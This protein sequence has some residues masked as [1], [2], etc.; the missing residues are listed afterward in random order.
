V[1]YPNHI[2]NLC[3]RKRAE[4]DEDPTHECEEQG[5]L[6]KKMKIDS[7]LPEIQRNLA[8]LK[9][10]VHQGVDVKN[11]G[12]FSLSEQHRFVAVPALFSAT[13]SD[14]ISIIDVIVG[15]YTH[16]PIIEKAPTDPD[17]LIVPTDIDTEQLIE[18]LEPSVFLTTMM[19]SANTAGYA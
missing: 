3:S 2:R 19:V 8:R 5:F 14:K 10:L 13:L 17:G 11:L 16:F 9:A 15:N 1:I 6:S 18:I 7:L 4:E 12:T